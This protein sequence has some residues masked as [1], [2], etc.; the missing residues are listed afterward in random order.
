V[1]HRRVAL[2]PRTVQHLLER[3]GELVALALMDT[4]RLQRI[5][6][7]QGR[8]IL[9]LEGLSP[10]VGHA[11]LWVRRDCLSSEGLLARSVLPAAPDDLAALLRAAK[12]AL[13]G[14]MAGVISDGQRSIR[15]ALG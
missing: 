7:A 8:V 11:G 13:G 2:A 5:T 10:A 1:V 3:D 14:A 4:A 6:E 12:Q 15:R 9:A